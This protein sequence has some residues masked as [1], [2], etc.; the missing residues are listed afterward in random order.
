MIEG[1]RDWAGGR[2]R[3]QMM[4]RLGWT[5]GASWDPQLLSFSSLEVDDGSWL[6]W[7]NELMYVEGW[8]QGVIHVD[9]H[10]DIDQ[11]Q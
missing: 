4:R 1:T 3:G 5:G 2:G 8:P 6:A 9:I 7:C 10:D 11:H